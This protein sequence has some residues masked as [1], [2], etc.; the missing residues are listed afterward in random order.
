M[1]NSEMHHRR[2]I[3]LKEYD[4]ASVGAYFVTVCTQNRECLLGNIYNGGMVL[5]EAGKMVADWWLKLPEKFPVIVLGEFV[6]MPDHFHGIIILND[7]GRRG[8][9]LCS[10]AFDTGP[11]AFDAGSPADDQIQNQGECR[12][13]QGEHKV[14]PYGTLENTLGRIMQELKSF[15]TNAY[16]RGVKDN[17]WSPFPG[18][19]WQRNYYE[20]VIRNE[21]EMASIS[22]Y[23][24]LNPMRWSEDKENPDVTDRVGA[25]LAAPEC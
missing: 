13:N 25:L 6:I 4:Y 5:N 18:R 9:T 22:E 2:S 16:I 11:P 1:Y 7:I 10:P 21:S 24:A 12:Q 3:R 14:R 19:L 15:T 17:N 8:D 20:R 23:I